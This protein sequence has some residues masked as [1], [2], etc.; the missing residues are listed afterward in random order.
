MART[1]REAW[2][3]CEGESGPTNSGLYASQLLRLRPKDKRLLPLAFY[4]LRTYLANCGDGRGGGWT[5]VTFGD[6]V[7]S[8][9]GPDVYLEETMPTQSLPYYSKNASGDPKPLCWFI[10]R[11]RPFPTP[12]M[13]RAGVYKS[14]CVKNFQLCQCPQILHVR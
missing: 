13:T 12:L 9:L 11:A 7:S 8:T 5:S 14:L 10:S 1:P 2:A 6:G 4:I 3:W